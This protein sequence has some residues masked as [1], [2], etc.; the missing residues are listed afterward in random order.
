MDLEDQF[1]QKYGRHV[2]EFKRCANFG[3]SSDGKL[4][5]F[6]AIISDTAELKMIAE[7]FN[8]QQMVSVYN[9]PSEFSSAPHVISKRSPSYFLSKKDEIIAMHGLMDGFSPGSCAVFTDKNTLIV[10]GTPQKFA[11]SFATLKGTLGELTRKNHSE[12]KAKKQYVEVE[13]RSLHDSIAE[14]YGNVLGIKPE[15]V[16]Q[17]YVFNTVETHT[18][19][20]FKLCIGGSNARYNIENRR[21]DKS[22]YTHYQLTDAYNGYAATVYDASIINSKTFIPCDF[23][24]VEGEYRDI[25]DKLSIVGSF[26]SVMSTR[27]TQP[28]TDITLYG[29]LANDDDSYVSL[30]NLLT[31]HKSSP[32]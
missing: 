27:S 30:S 29:H 4:Y 2:L 5:G 17:G 16:N 22:G 18:D 13:T 31:H 11:A 28:P 1:K 15:R 24:H 23:G 26:H 6:E 32:S 9:F 20:T 12:W 8:L 19:D 3:T 21:P 25:R 10:R 14:Q 7:D